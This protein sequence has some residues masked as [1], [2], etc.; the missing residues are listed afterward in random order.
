MNNYSEF[1]VYIFSNNRDI[2]KCQSFCTTP[3]PPLTTPGLFENSQAKKKK[4]KKQRV[5]HIGF[6][7]GINHFFMHLSSTGPEEDEKPE[8]P[9]V[10]NL[11]R[12]RAKGNALIRSSTK[13]F[14]KFA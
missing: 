8:G 2:R 14:V 6:I 12:H 10:A 13:Y 3:P 1:Q 4:G 5:H 7:V 9:G 11:Q